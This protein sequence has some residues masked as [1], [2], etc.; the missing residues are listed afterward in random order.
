MATPVNSR[1]LDLGGGIRAEMVAHQV[2]LFYDP[3]TSG[4][5]AIFNGY[6]YILTGETWRRVGDVND[7]LHVDLKDLMLLRPA[8]GMRDPVTGA[9]LSNITVAGVLTIFKGAYNLFHNRRAAEQRAQEEIR[10]DLSGKGTDFSPDVPKLEEAEAI[11]IQ[12][13]A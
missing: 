13:T 12:P 5:R 1:F 6:P 9:D 10:K 4:A 3:T 11:E 2:Q 7:I 8:E